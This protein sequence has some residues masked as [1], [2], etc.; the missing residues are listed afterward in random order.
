MQLLGAEASVGGLPDIHVEGVQS[1]L[2]VRR[3]KTL[4]HDGLLLIQ[5]T[6]NYDITFDPRKVI[7]TIVGGERRSRPATE[8]LAD[9]V[10]SCHDVIAL[11][12]SPHA[13]IGYLKGVARSQ[14]HWQP[15]L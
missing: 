9:Q 13:F 1:C 4:R 8:R 11:N 15:N 7:S 5:R 6:I 3:C 10:C 12:Y 2:I 14:R